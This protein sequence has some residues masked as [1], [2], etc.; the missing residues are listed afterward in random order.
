M[1]NER[2]TVSQCEFIIGVSEDNVDALYQCFTEN[3]DDDQCQVSIGLDATNAVATGAIA[4]YMAVSNVAQVSGVYS[5]F[6]GI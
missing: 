1:A 5:G 3:D 4:G 6:P 2:V